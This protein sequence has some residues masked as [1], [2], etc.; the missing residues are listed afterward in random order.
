M[1][2]GKISLNWRNDPDN[3]L[4]DKIIYLLVTNNTRKF[5]DKA[6]FKNIKQFTKILL[7][8]YSSCRRNIITVTQ[9]DK[10]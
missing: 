5:K 6:G 7:Q 1:S 4:M 9:L 3:L 10:V 8:I 2:S